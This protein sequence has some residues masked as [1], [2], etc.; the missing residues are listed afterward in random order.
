MA[1]YVVRPGF[2]FGAMDQYGPGDIV[3]L[4]HEEA[5][6][7]ADKLEVVAK[8][9]EVVAAQMEVTGEDE[10]LP[11]AW[12]DVSFDELS[13][14]MAM[15]RLLIAA[16]YDSPDSVRLASDADLLAV[17]GIGKRSLGALRLVL[18]AG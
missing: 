15:I 1:D 4:T 3:Q 16:G 5:T 10:G 11:G 18:G 8:S 2:R 17:K 9:T 6:S 12:G 13:K 7:F 14:H